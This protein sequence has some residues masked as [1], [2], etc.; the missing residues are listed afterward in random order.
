MGFKHTGILAERE[1]KLPTPHPKLESAV[2]HDGVFPQSSTLSILV[3]V[4]PCAYLLSR[5]A[6][7][8]DVQNI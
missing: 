5:I 7:G 2:P 3:R 1:T 4:I 8:N 6:D